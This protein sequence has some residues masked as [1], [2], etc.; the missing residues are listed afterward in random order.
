MNATNQ[1][2]VLLIFSNNYQTD[3]LTATQWIQEVNKQKTEA[4]WT[5]LQ[6]ITQI[7]KALKGELTDWF[8][9]LKL[10]EPSS[11]VRPRLL[12]GR[13]GGQPQE[14]AASQLAG[15]PA[16]GPSGQTAVLQVGM[17]G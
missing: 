1:Q 10:L 13:C 15:Q 3:K 4:A 17:D 6:T 2:T 9:S 5:D 8:Y 14:E 7:Q 11:R 16:P 12:V